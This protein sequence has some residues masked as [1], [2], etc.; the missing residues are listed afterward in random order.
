MRSD[1]RHLTAYQLGCE[2]GQ[3]VV[4]ILRPAILDRHVL[5]FDVP[6]FANA[7]PECRHKTR[8]VGRR[9]DA[10][11]PDPRHCRLLRVRRERPRR[12]AAN[13]RDEVP[14]PHYSITSSARASSEGG[15]VRPS[16]LAVVRFTTKSNLV[17]CSTGISAGF[18]PRRTLSTTSAAR[19]HMF[20]QCGP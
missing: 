4:L 1:H 16:A 17:G 2:V 8:S 19:L 5:T 11:E 3:Y 20:G 18:A 7:L 6:G 14:S 15:T 13:Q 10:E 12:R 9:R